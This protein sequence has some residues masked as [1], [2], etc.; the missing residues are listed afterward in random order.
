MLVY[1]IPDEKVDEGRVELASRN[2]PHLFQYDLK[3]QPF[4]VGPV[5]AHGVIK[6][7]DGYY[8]GLNRYLKALFTAGVARAVEVLV[9]GADYA[10]HELHHRYSLKD[11]LAYLGVLLYPAALLL[12]KRPLLVE[13]GLVHAYLAEV[14]EQ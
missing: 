10:G 6:V 12:G 1:G 2:P 8:P 5:A 11:L 14:V 13:D 7:G 3:R 4:S 9:V